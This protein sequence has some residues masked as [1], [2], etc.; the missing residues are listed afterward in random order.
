MWW[1]RK[2]RIRTIAEISIQTN[3]LQVKKH[4]LYQEIAT[5]AL[6]LK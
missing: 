4:P 2:E 1:A 3:L 5:T 6:R